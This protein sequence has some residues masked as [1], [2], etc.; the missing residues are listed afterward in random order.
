MITEQV[1]CTRLQFPLAI[2]GGGAIAGMFAQSV[3]FNLT[4][5]LQAG[6]FLGSIR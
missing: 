2:L 1:P 3:P 6:M 5:S 4:K